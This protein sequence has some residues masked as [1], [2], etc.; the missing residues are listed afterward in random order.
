M[1]LGL[2]LF[3]LVFAH[4]ASPEATSRHIA[5]GSGVVAADPM[6]H[7]PAVSGGVVVG[8]ASDVAVAPGSHRHDHPP[9]HTVEECA[10][11]QPPQGPDVDLPC[12]SPLGAARQS[13]A[14]VAAGAQRVAGR[15]FVVPIAHAADSTIL[16]V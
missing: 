9:S 7:A 14:P 10:L 8:D 11:G 1:G 5:A 2:V 13:G 12:L 15:D 4:A 3:G 6:S 16:R